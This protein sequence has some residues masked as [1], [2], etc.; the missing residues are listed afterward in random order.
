MKKICENTSQFSIKHYG[1]FTNKK[2]QNTMRT[3]QTP[4]NSVDTAAPVP[5]GPPGIGAG[6]GRF[7]ALGVAFAPVRPLCSAASFLLHVSETE[8]LEMFH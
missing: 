2:L 8:T 3:P 4:R 1:C 5:A 6:F 7:E